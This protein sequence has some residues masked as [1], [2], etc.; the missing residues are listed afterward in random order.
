MKL[1]EGEDGIPCECRSFLFGARFLPVCLHGVRARDPSGLI[2]DDSNPP[3]A[4]SHADPERDGAP[5][6]SIR[7]ESPE[8]IHMKSKTNPAMGGG[9]APPRSSWR[10]SP[11]W[12]SCSQRQLSF[13]FPTTCLLIPR[14]QKRSAN[15][16]SY[17]RIQWMRPLS[18]IR[19]R[20]PGMLQQQQYPVTRA[21]TVGYS[22]K[23]T[24]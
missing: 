4:R 23:G 11:F 13:L 16:R 1:S 8:V 3:I 21:V 2:S 7:G 19:S 15:T 14:K 17:L 9:Q 5:S 12:R 10:Q 18:E 24:D 20:S 22:T 6:A